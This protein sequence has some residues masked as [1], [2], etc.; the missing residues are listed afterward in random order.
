MSL[1]TQKIIEKMSETKIQFLEKNQTDKP[2]TRL[3]REKR[4]M[5][6]VSEVKQ[7]YHYRSYR[8]SEG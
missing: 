7:D 3:A 8:L 6:P 5:T 2:L 1:K 4:E